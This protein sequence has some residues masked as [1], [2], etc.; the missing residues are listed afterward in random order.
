MICCRL[1]AMQPDAS[2]PGVN[3]GSVVQ[4]LRG[5]SSRTLLDVRNGSRWRFKFT[6]FPLRNYYQWE[7]PADV[8]SQVVPFE[9]KN[10]RRIS[11]VDF[12]PMWDGNQDMSVALCQA[13]RT[14]KTV[15]TLELFLNFGTLEER[16][17]TAI[18]DSLLKN[19]TLQ[20]FA[21][22]AGHEFGFPNHLASHETIR[23]T[24][25][26]IL[27]W[28]MCLVEIS[29]RCMRPV[30]LGPT[31]T[32]AIERNKRAWIVAKHLGQLNRSSADPCQNL[33]D[34]V[35]RRLVL[36]FFLANGCQEPPRQML[37]IAGGLPVWRPVSRDVL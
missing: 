24:F 31:V 3:I 15:R 37:Y 35:L 25:E 28:N 36:R 9:D 7:R 22:L 33:G 20:S 19:D 5:N 11:R 8:M 10:D 4:A 32:K 29:I 14:N 1:Y 21:F 17:L 2:P 34:I 13:M 18:E 23:D 16:H 6:R 26:R 12:V 27:Q 30:N